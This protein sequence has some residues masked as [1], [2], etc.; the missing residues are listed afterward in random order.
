MRIFI[1][2]T[3]LALA[4]CGQKGALYMPAEP[5]SPQPASE[6]PVKP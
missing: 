2:I 6:E 1:L 4:A 5:A 3:L